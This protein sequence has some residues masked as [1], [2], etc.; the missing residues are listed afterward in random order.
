MGRETMKADKIYTNIIVG[1]SSIFLLISLILF[2][3]GTIFPNDSDPYVGS[4]DTFDFSEGWEL[5]V[6]GFTEPTTVNLPLTVNETI[7]HTVYLRKTLPMDIENNMSLCIRSTMN[8]IYV[9]VDGNLR[10][11][12]ASVNYK[13]MSYNQPSAYIFCDISRLDAGKTVEIKQFMKTT[14]VLNSVSYGYSGNLYYHIYSESRMTVIAAYILITIGIVIICVHFIMKKRRG[15]AV[16]L[17]YTGELALAMGLWLISES[18]LRQWLFASFSPSAIYCY[19]TIELLPL[20][21]CLFFDSVQKKRYHKLY[22]PI[23]VVIL[24]QFIVNTVLAVG[25]V[26][27]YYQTLFM[28]HG[29][30]IVGILISIITIIIDIKRKHIKEYFFIA[31]GMGLFILLSAG[32]LAV[33]YLN[34]LITLG[35]FLSIGI[36]VL[37]AF[38]VIQAVYNEI[39]H[40][41]ERLEIQ[42]RFTLKTLESFAEAIDSKSDY[43]G[44]HSIRVARYSAILARA[45][46]DKYNF[47]EDDIIKIHNIGLMHDIGKIAIPDSIL[48]SR[49]DMT[50]DEASLIRQHVILGEMLLSPLENIEWLFYGIRSHHER[51]DGKGYPD[52]L[53]GT[54]IPLV[55]RIICLANNYDAMVYGHVYGDMTKSQIRARIEAE[56]GKRFDPDMVPIMCRLIDNDTI[57][58][59]V[60]LDEESS[61]GPTVPAQS[62]ILD[63]LIMKK[64]SSDNEFGL[65]QPEQIGLVSYM[66]K[67]SERVNSKVDIYLIGFSDAMAKSMKK[68]E[69]EDKLAQIKS[70]LNSSTTLHDILINFTSNLLL[71]MYINRKDSEIAKSLTSFSDLDI[72]EELFIRRIT[73]GI[74]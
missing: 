16:S 23:E 3:V 61:N 58:P 36:I 29:W 32:E 71:L 24:G 70:T 46:A 17:L 1:A 65:I 56:A 8:D 73:P 5:T 41:R 50:E 57:S 6:D 45:M 53:K 72:K 42:E 11:S 30:M 67:L 66:A 2:F 26:A 33:F 34:K 31:I 64:M 28:S 20:F 9:Y 74:L 19:I 37:V 39:R 22:L 68:D 35:F 38:S 10:G 47:T 25:R 54:D 43:T 15:R 48:N 21:A 69:L 62:K 52:G 14:G 4:F 40:G 63:S 51:F 27:T 12:Y 13:S 49:E 60:P 18:K 55:A 44:G 7:G 59:D